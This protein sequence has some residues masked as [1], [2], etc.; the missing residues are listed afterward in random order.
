MLVI[1]SMEQDKSKRRKIGDNL[2]NRDGATVLK[3]YG[4]MDK[5]EE[6]L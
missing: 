4:I 3:F 6:I 2:W 1:I 5:K